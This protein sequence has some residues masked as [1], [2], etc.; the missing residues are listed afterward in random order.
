[1][2]R[3]RRPQPQIPTYLACSLLCPVP[4]PG[5]AA[6]FFSS[7]RAW[8]LTGRVIP[9]DPGYGDTGRLKEGREM[10]T[11]AV[12]A[13][14]SWKAPGLK[15]EE[16]S[17]SVDILVMTRARSRGHAHGLALCTE[18][19]AYFQQISQ[20]QWQ[21]HSLISMSCHRWSWDMFRSSTLQYFLQPPIQGDP[22]SH[23][24]KGCRG[25]NSAFSL[26]I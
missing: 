4:R 8:M 5:T 10:L 19:T 9:W 12:E 6:G 21:E 3:G 16:I 20:Q 23:K 13:G 22:P 18:H 11:R 24:H 25:F 17:V 1:M 26:K 14:S 2:P 7:C 15:D